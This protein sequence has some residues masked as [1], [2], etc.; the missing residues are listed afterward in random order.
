MTLLY[1]PLDDR[2]A[3]KWHQD[4]SYYPQ[5]RSEETGLVIWCPLINVNKHNGTIQV[6]PGS[7]KVG[8]IEVPSQ[9]F[10][11]NSSEQFEIMELDL[12]N[13]GLLAHAVDFNAASGDV[14]LFHMN[15]IHRSGNNR[16]GK[17]RVVAGCRAHN[18]ASS[19][20]Q[21]K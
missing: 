16:S 13:N 11:S 6:I 18:S 9:V 1:S 10:G 8:E 20:F 15:L 14:G 19:N 21:V 4:V 12:E 17:F 7:H 2:N 3:L 5:N